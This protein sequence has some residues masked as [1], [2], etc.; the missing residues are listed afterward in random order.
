MALSHQHMILCGRFVIKLVQKLSLLREAEQLTERRK[1]TQH[2]VLIW[3]NVH[4]TIFVLHFKLQL[5]TEYVIKN[6]AVP[7]YRCKKY[8]TSFLQGVR[9]T[10]KAL[11]GQHKRNSTSTI[12]LFYF[13]QHLCI[14]YRSYRYT[15]VAVMTVVWALL[16][17]RFGE[18]ML[19]YTS[20]YTEQDSN[21]GTVATKGLMS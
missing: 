6:V 4:E 21:T 10:F 12:E 18:N 1:L 14:D 19:P 8:Y 7:L 9:R 20:R 13:L 3:Q 16:G 15:P 17:H 11:R 5:F 2:Y